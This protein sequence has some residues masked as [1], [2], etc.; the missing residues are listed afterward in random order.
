M[1]AALTPV[2]KIQFFA[3][4]GTPLVGGKLYS[5]AAGTTTP[6]ATYTTY[7]GTV[8]NTNPVIL[9]S[10]GEANVWL[11]ANVYKLALYDADNALIWTVDNITPVGDAALVSYLP[12]GTGAVA[13]TVQAKLRES[14]SVKDFGAVGDGTTNDAAAIQAAITAA[15]SLGAAVNFSGLTYLVSSTLTIP[16]GAVLIG[17]PGKTTIKASS[18][19]ADGTSLLQTT[20]VSGTL[21]VFEYRNISI[22]GITFDGSNRTLTTQIGLV[23]IAKTD[24]ITV[25][26]CSFLG[27]R[28]INLALLGCQN[29]QIERCEWSGWGRTDVS[30]EG[31]AAL[32]IGPNSVD[33]TTS[34]YG[35]VVYNNFHDGE[36]SAIYGVC[37]GVAFSYNIVNNTKEGLYFRTYDTT[38]TTGSQRLQIIGNVIT[39]TTKKYI[40]SAGM[41]VGGWNVSILHNDI[42]TS[43]GPGIDITDVAENIII[44][45]NL[46][47]NT[48]TD[49][50]TYPS[51]GQITVRATSVSALKPIHVMITENR[52]GDA[53]VTPVAP[54]GIIV[55]SIG[56]TQTTNPLIVRTNDVTNAAASS[57][58][59]LFIE[60]AAY[61]ASAIVEGNIG[62]ASETPYVGQIQLTATTGS[63]VITGVGF[64]PR[65]ITIDAVVT[66][67]TVASQST[68]ARARNAIGAFAN[69]THAS[70]GFRGGQQSGSIIYL[71]NAAGTVV[72]N[73][74]VLTF[75]ADGFTLDVTVASTS[76]NTLYTCYP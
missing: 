58:N 22:N 51:Y 63:Q 6:L 41:E 35:N 31:G 18:G 25:K 55:R 19:L 5:Y 13:T 48:V 54:Y 11:G 71:V 56:V 69:F 59:N 17:V 62:S 60:A 29:L 43:Q 70:T 76:P 1:T 33:L 21:N 37:Q 23:R 46:V 75:D 7:A 9:D 4:D 36:W 53:N 32:F 57:A 30:V 45:H 15:A 14:V 49:T 66:S 50:T 65:L 3:D 47:R 61:G 27:H 26:N 2:P 67:A 68:G 10:R 12:A 34:R 39:N 38:P 72:F 28:Y 42:D 73:A 74:S 52:V 40:Q 8:A 16:T 44:S 64:K 20:T 24:G